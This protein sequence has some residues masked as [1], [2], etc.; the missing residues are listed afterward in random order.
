MSDPA[1]LTPDVDLP[2]EAVDAAHKALCQRFNE[3]GFGMSPSQIDEAEQDAR[4][5]LAAAMPVI[6]RQWEAEEPG[7][8]FMVTCDDEGL[9][10]MAE[11][12]GRTLVYEPVIRRHL[13]DEIRGNLGFPVNGAYWLGW[14]DG[15]F[16]GEQVARGPVWAE[17]PRPE[18]PIP[19]SRLR[20]LEA[21]A[22]PYEPQVHRSTPRR[23]RPNP[24]GSDA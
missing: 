4:A 15:I 9:P 13:A 6:R 2:A 12:L 24:G 14:R 17:A 23:P 5:A 19:E 21:D 22:E 20:A 7:P 18:R 8:S 3:Q 10:V 16:R 1:V 11:Y